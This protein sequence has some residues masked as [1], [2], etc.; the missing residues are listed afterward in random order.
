[1]KSKTIKLYCSRK[2]SEFGFYWDST[3]EIKGN[4]SYNFLVKNILQIQMEILE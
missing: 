3:F 1:M 4:N 2:L